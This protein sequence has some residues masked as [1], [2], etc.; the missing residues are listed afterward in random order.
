MSIPNVMLWPRRLFAAPLSFGAGLAALTI[1]LGGC[2]G[3]QQPAAASSQQAA[4]QDGPTAAAP[5]P[6]KPAAPAPGKAAAV[7]AG[8][9]PVSDVHELHPG[10]DCPLPGPE[11]Q[12]S[13][14]KAGPARIPLKVGL[15]LS[16][17]WK[18][19]ADDYEH[20]C[21]TQVTAVDAR[22]VSTT[23]SCPLGPN[24]DLV[25]SKRRICWTDILNSY[26]YMT[27]TDSK[28]PDTFV[29]ALQFN[30]SQASFAALKSNGE[31][32]HR[33]MDL[34]DNNQAYIGTDI[35]G[36]VKSEGAGT[37]KVIINDKAVEVPTIEG[38]S[39]NLKDNHLIRIKVLD[40][41]AFPFVLDYFIPSLHRFF[42]TYTKVSFPTPRELEQS[43]A[44]DK[45]TDVYGIYFDFA[46]ATLRAESHPVLQEIADALNAHPDWT[47]IINGHTDNIGGDPDN[48]ALSRQRAEAVRAALAREF[49]IAE[50]RLSVNGLG[51]SQPKESND[52]DRGRAL[53]RRVELVRR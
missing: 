45:H 48:L 35:E 49:A 15:T 28:Y 13:I 32:H 23:A 33:Y 14:A 52:S 41:A 17:V 43:L 8:D 3:A 44:Q 36:T 24:R 9:I 10:A 12:A 11:L 47:L 21:L 2:S 30:L 29:G 31:F 25:Q 42:I 19:N 16:H 27:S 7:Q 50:S 38:V 5:T 34:D 26:I 6:V 51:A 18:R 37:F 1:A 22:S 39:V 4:S 46:K 40:D 53:N 20:E